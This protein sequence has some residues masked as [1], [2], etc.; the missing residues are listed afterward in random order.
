MDEAITILAMVQNPKC[1]QEILQKVLECDQSD[2]VS[3]CAASHSNCPP[4]ALKMVLKMGRDDG[5]SCYAAHNSNCPPEALQMVLERGND[6]L[7]SWNAA[8]NP[9]CPSQARL[10]WLMATGQIKMPDLSKHDTQVIKDYNK[11]N[12]EWEQFKKMVQ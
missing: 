11:S 3:W 1:S 2:W 8:H 7:V 9:N 10:K 12:E 4:E 5:V 6:D